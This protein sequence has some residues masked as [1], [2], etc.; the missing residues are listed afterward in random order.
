MDI[1]FVEEKTSRI[2][3]WKVKEG[4]FLPVG[5]V[6]FSYVELLDGQPVPGIKRLKT[7]QSGV[8]KTI[9]AKNGQTISNGCVLATLESCTHPT[10]MRDMC[11]EC[12]KDLR[13]SDEAAPSAVSMIHS[14]PDLRIS[15]EQ[16]QK[17]GKIDEE[18]LLG[19][20][21]LVLLV[22]LDQ[23]LIHT[24]NDNVPHNL[25]DVFHFQLWGHG[26]VWY[27]TRLRPRT[28][29][30]LE[31]VSK[32][33]ELHI[34][35]FGTRS[36]AHV[37]ASHLDSRGQF[38]SDRILSRDEC[39]SQNSKTANLKELFPRGDHMVCIIDDREDVWNF[40]PNLIHVKPYH[41]FRHT[42][43]IN[44]PPG[45]TKQDDDDK[46]GFTF[47]KDGTTTVPES[48]SSEASSPESMD[49]KSTES[50][51]DCDTIK[52]RR[53]T[54]DLSLSDEEDSEHSKTSDDAIEGDKEESCDE[55]KDN[56]VLEEEESTKKP[57][58]KMETDE[59]SHQVV[60]ENIK[61]DPTPIHNTTEEV[62][63]EDQDDYLLYLEEILQSIHQ[64][65]YSLYNDTN[66]PDVKNVVPYVRR[67]VLK[68]MSIVFS[69]V[70]PTEV[71]VAERKNTKAYSVATSLGAYV[72]ERI[73]PPNKPCGS[74]E[75]PTT[76][77]IAARVGTAK[78]NE[79]RRYKGIHI[80][81]PDWLWCCSERWKLVDERLFQLYKKS[82]VNRYPPGHHA[83]A[84]RDDLAF[85]DNG[86]A[87]NGQ[88][89]QQKG[90]GGV[91]AA[92][93]ER[94]PSG[95]FMDT[96]NPLL[97]FSMDEIDSMGHEVDDI[98][99]ESESSSTEEEDE[100]AAEGSSS[101]GDVFKDKVLKRRTSNDMLAK[102]DV[103]DKLGN[104]SSS[105]STSNSGSS[106]ESSTESEMSKSRKRKRQNK[107]ETE[108]EDEPLNVKFRRGEGVPSEVEH[109]M[110]TSEDD[111]TRDQDEEWMAQ[112]LEREFMDD[113]DSQ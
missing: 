4:F 27:H 111:G 51:E 71:P 68:N 90:G 56:V 35:T 102:M 110:L 103:S 33:Y 79:A 23:T 72:S 42:G 93:K 49:T 55:K 108:T 59:F 1:V 18:R 95:R 22:D 67:K 29:E 50:R 70:I 11:A 39:F 2:Q 44:A 96:I 87:K 37:I 43:D 17:I 19:Q 52:V 34:C 12:G 3:Q 58:D 28:I 5:H 20:R 9:H 45:L 75:I 40:A 98:L 100:E 73:I 94:T 104:N 36:Y 62:E 7:T 16:A 47:N 30:F 97:S 109:L 15:M 76:H 60:G 48:L 91:A 106:S 89:Q 77:V 105:S 32:L 8:I 6:I 65:F 54:S 69:G 82:I 63:V 101:A 66:V 84:R 21:K 80:V 25:K 14:V 88:I 107:T 99:N 10:V 81:T 13:K 86:A 46:T 41:F 64:A 61:V 112:E 92:R 85:N 38:F 74:T 24:T 113:D 78:V 53:V 83:F 57:D 31:S 26:S